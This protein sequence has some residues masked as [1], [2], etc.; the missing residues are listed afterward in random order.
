MNIDYVARAGLLGRL[1][2]A[3][4][5]AVLS[6]FA[7]G[8]ERV[9]DDIT[10]EGLRAQLPGDQI[11][12]RAGGSSFN[13]LR[14][15]SQ[16]G[17]FR[18]GF[19]GCLG[20]EPASQPITASLRASGIETRFVEPAPHRACG[21]CL[22]LEIDGER[23]LL[24]TR[25]ANDELTRRFEAEAVSI[26][27]YISG[28]ILVHV[29]SLLDPGAPAALLK[30]LR[31]ARSVNPA[32]KISLDPGA[33]WSLALADTAELREMAALADWVFL[34]Q[35]EFALWE[36]GGM[37]RSAGGAVFLR[38]APDHIL[39]LNSSS[40]GDHSRLRI[41]NQVI[42]PEMILDPTGAGDVF[43]AGVL[44]KLLEDPAEIGAAVSRGLGLARRKLLSV[45]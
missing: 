23:W 14:A 37:L 6:C 31:L 18:L 28:A 42:P 13:A 25:G 5:A 12:A 30:V 38:K 27:A 19:V 3:R 39:V 10:F 32:L 43:A 35:E 7:P 41:A 16:L 40:T 17:P 29:S 24:T 1:T 15:L 34:N 9:V 21:S 22:A 26:A 36:R 44:S 33:P 45:N 8:S 11:T 4:R 2:A 20:R